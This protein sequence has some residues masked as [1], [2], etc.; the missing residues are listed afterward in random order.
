MQWNKTCALLLVLSSQVYAADSYTIDPNHSYVQY[1]ISHFGFSQQSGKWFANG[2]LEFD[3]NHPQNSKTNVTIKIADID[4]GNPELNKHLKSNLFFDV[5]KYPEA[6]FVSDKIEA[7]GNKISKLHGTL[8]LHG[9]SKPVILNVKMNGMGINPVTNKETV[10]FSGQTQL[11][12]SE[13]G[14]NGF[15]PKIGDDVKL[16]IEVEAYK[17]AP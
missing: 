2:S 1:D 13:F 3:K 11:K 17:N 5:S 14:I 12:R 10:G 9:V 4:T 7:K 16:K 6:T 15:L 8:T